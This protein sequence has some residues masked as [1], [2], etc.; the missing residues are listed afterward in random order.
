MARRALNLNPVADITTREHKLTM[1]DLYIFF[2]AVETLCENMRASNAF[3]SYQLF[4]ELE[5]DEQDDEYADMRRKLYNALVRVI[6]VA[7]ADAFAT[8]LDL[9]QSPLEISSLRADDA[10][11][12][13]AIQRYTALNVGPLPSDKFQYFQGTSKHLSLFAYIDDA[14]RY[15]IDTFKIVHRLI[16][17][18]EEH[19]TRSHYDP[20]DFGYL[21]KA[22]LEEFYADVACEIYE[23]LPATAMQQIHDLSISQLKWYVSTCPVNSIK[24]CED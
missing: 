21:D 1:R 8:K 3:M 11:H 2:R 4:P 12:D 13:D 15:L 14:E 22:M 20:K 6:D 16:L 9:V 7:Q 5:D 10:E 18:F 19:A 23:V 24:Y 17:K